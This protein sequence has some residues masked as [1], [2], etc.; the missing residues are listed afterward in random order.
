MAGSGNQRA[1]LSHGSFDHNFD[2]KEQIFR[3]LAQVHEAMLIAPSDDDTAGPDFLGKRPS[4]LGFLV[5]CCACPRAPRQLLPRRASWCHL[6]TAH[7]EARDP[8]A[9]PNLDARDTARGTGPR[10]GRTREEGAD[11]RRRHQPVE[12]AWGG[13]GPVCGSLGGCA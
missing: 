2:S 10:K 13:L 12:A 9:H 6:N 1:G 8:G 3:K 5:P 4:W 11:L 7:Q